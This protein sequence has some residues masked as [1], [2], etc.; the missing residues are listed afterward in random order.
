MKAIGRLAA[1]TELNKSNPNYVN[2]D[3]YRLLFKEDLMIAAY[4]KIKSKGANADLDGE[5]LEKLRERIVQLKNEK[6][7]FKPGKT[8]KRPID[9]GNTYDKVVLEAVRTI[10]ES[11]YEGNFKETSHGFRPNKG[12]HTALK[13]VRILFRGT[14]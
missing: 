14:K 10:L 2:K 4:E 8:T 1:I 6:Y 11:I 7:T 5:S 3:L 9:I 13:E 12:C